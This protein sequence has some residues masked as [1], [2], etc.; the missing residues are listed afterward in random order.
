[1]SETTLKRSKTNCCRGWLFGLPSGSLFWVLT[2]VQ[3]LAVLAGAE[4]PGQS[5]TYGR[6]DVTGAAPQPRIDGVVVY[7]PVSRRLFLFGGRAA[8]PLNDLWTYSIDRRTWAEV[9]VD[10]LRPPARSGHTMVLDPIRARLVVFGGQAAGFFS[11]T[12]AFELAKS[13]W[14]QLLPNDSGPSRRYGHSAILD[15][16]RDRMVISHGFTNAGRFDDTWAFELSSDSWRDISPASDRPLRRC[17]H[18]AAYDPGNDQ[19]LLYGGCASGVGPCPLGDLWSFD[20]SSQLWTELLPSPQ[21]PARQ[22]YGMT[23]DRVRGRLVVFGG[24][25]PGLLNDTWEYDPAAGRWE[26][27]LIEGDSPAPRRRHETAFAADIGAIFFFGGALAAGLTNE[28]WRLVPA[29][30]PQ[31]PE[32]GVVNAFSFEGGVVAPGEIVSLF[33]VG[34]GPSSGIATQFDSETGRLPDSV[35]G[36]SV[37]WNGIPTPLYFVLSGQLNVQVPYELAESLEAE[38]IV[39]Y[40]GLPSDTVLVPL[41]S[42]HPG[43]FPRVFNQDGTVNSPA[44]P[45]FPGRVVVVYGTGQGVTNPPSVSGGFPTGEFPVPSAPLSLFVGGVAAEIL[46]QGQAPFTAGVIQVNARLSQATP[47]GDA[48]PVVLEIGEARSQDGV[49]VAVR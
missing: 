16:T 21:P 4:L 48:V 49:T 42:T 25:G 31:L 41:A 15:A 10:G 24:S 32:A 46:F 39:F 43:L 7:E 22:W 8:G 29:V 44:N 40:N 6:L 28:V 2:S 38:L 19:M 27:P 12:W 11:D 20:L 26:Q 17:L 47:L 5:L 34:L 33:G 45:E 23:F 18:H 1:M 14:Q 37:A 13:S 35:S 36:V 3:V 9:P 30:H